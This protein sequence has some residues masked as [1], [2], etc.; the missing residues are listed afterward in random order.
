[1]TG[2]SRAHLSSAKIYLIPGYGFE[3]LFSRELEG[4]EGHNSPPVKLGIW[5]ATT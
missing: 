5:A 2:S 4:S 1:M 3:L